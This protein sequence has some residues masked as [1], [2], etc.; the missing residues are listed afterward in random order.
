MTWVR[1]VRWQIRNSNLG[2]KGR[3][4]TDNIILNGFT[5]AVVGFWRGARKSMWIVYISRSWYQTASRQA[6]GSLACK[7]PPIAKKLL[8]QVHN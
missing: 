3:A 1:F 6:N 8:P 5:A 7:P 2:V 4:R